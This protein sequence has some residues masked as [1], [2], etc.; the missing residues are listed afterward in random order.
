MKNFINY[1]VVNKNIKMMNDDDGELVGEYPVYLC[2]TM[3]E[4]L[5]VMQFPTVPAD[6]ANVIVQPRGGRVRPEHRVLELEMED[7]EWKHTETYEPDN[8]LEPS[9]ARKGINRRKFTSDFVPSKSQYCAGIFTGDG[10]QRALHIVPLTGFFAMRPSLDHVD[11]VH[12]EDNSTTKNTSKSSSFSSSSSSSSSSNLFTERHLVT[13]KMEKAET[14]R[15]KA[16]SER[17]YQTLRDDIDSENW[18]KLSY[19]NSESQLSENIMSRILAAQTLPDRRSEFKVEPAKYI[20]AWSPGGFGRS[21]DALD[22]VKAA[23]KYRDTVIQEN[24]P[25]HMDNDDVDVAAIYK[26]RGTRSLFTFA[27]L[28]SMSGVEQVCAVLKHTQVISFKRLKELC[29]GFL[30][31]SP[32]NTSHAHRNLVRALDNHAHF[33]AGRWVVKSVDVCSV[34]KGQPPSFRDRL[35]LELANNDGSVDRKVLSNILKCQPKHCLLLLEPL[36]RLNPTTR[37]WEFKVPYDHDFVEEFSVTAKKQSTLWASSFKA[38]EINDALL[39]D[40]NNGYRLRPSTNSHVYINMVNGED[41]HDND[42]DYK[43]S[44]IGGSFNSSSRSSSSSNSN[45]STSSGGNNSSGSNSSNSNSSLSDSKSR[46][47]HVKGKIQTPL[48]AALERH[49]VQAYGDLSKI[50]SNHEGYSVSRSVVQSALKEIATCVKIN[51]KPLY[52]LKRHIEENGERRQQLREIVLDLYEKEG[53]G[54]GGFKKVDII[55]YAKKRG[56]ETVPASLFNTVM[57]EFAISNKA[58]WVFKMKDSLGKTG[59]K[60]R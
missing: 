14:D 34:T 6:R 37:R 32:D 48:M 53:N 30:I 52:V 22:A 42:G 56:M 43:M 24:D 1:L 5:H 18:V 46:D 7:Q 31:E 11:H 21:S 51:G 16:R 17:A 10:D 33:V 55:N 35:L 4:E 41:Q 20:N 60:K 12:Q 38:N 47:L 3:P 29:V 23:D 13:T 58:V 57:K 49:G 59:G 39:N 19:E 36:T 40:L 2:H 25:H 28:N 50:A 15:S 44:N 45:N 54:K 27:S 8:D 9:N 26:I